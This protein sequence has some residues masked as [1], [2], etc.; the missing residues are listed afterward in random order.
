MRQSPAVQ[1][2]IALKDK[3]AALSVL[4]VRSGV[5][6]LF[7]SVYKQDGK[8]DQLDIDT[9]SHRSLPLCIKVSCAMWR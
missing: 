7:S 4:I 3:G 2:K 5:S 6:I 8:L 1:P 9:W